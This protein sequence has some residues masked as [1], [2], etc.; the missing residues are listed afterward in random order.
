[1]AADKSFIKSLRHGDIQE[2]FD[3][4]FFVTGTVA[5]S[6]PV[7]M[8]FSRNMT[9]IKD[10]EDLTLLN[11]LRLDEA[12]LKQLDKLGEV[13]NVIRLAAFHGMDDPFYKHRYSAKVWSVNTPYVAGFNKSPK[14]EEMYFTPDVV[15]KDSTQLP[16]IDAKFIEFTSCTPIESLLLLQRDGGIVISGDCLQNWSETDEYFSFVAK[17]MMK[18]MG[19]IK[20]YNLGPG[21]LK[22]AKPKAKEIRS[23]LELDF[24]HVLPAHGKPVTNGAKE[25][26]EPA[27]NKL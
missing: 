11:T 24:Q 5:M 12:G 3:D 9:I 2:I 7:P 8:R 10:G 4:I 22:I 23:I 19:F 26:Y 16:I 14:P 17:I 21:W 25:L 6:S 20:P 15:L 13:K 18:K 1:M 27:I